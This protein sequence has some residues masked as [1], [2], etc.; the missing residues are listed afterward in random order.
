MKVLITEDKL[1]SLFNSM[2]LE[3][4][5]LYEHERDYDYY[6]YNKNTYI[7]YSPL[8]FYNIDDNDDNNSWWE[9]DDWVFQYAENPPYNEPVDGFQTP[10]LIYSKY[11]FKSMLEMFGS[12][13]ND[14]LKVW[15]ESTYD[16]PIK[17]VIDDY[18]TDKFVRS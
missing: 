12:K 14:L 1:Q 15:F 7:D 13:F 11:S 3:F 18:S 5:N 16:Y 10:L 6:D 9:D 17:Q 4:A 2:M 8:N